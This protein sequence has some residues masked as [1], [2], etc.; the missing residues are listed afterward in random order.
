MRLSEVVAASRAVGGTSGRLDK[1]G[2]LADLLRRV[3]PEE[4]ETVIGFLSG[5]PRQGRMGIGGASLAGLRGGPAADAAPLDIPEGDAAFDQI[6]APSRAGSPSTPAEA[7]RPPFR[8]P[9]R[10]E[11]DF[12]PRP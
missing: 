11:P 5:A 1:V 9:P 10:G 4:I 8:P 7:L 6:A 12:P 2:H 3:P